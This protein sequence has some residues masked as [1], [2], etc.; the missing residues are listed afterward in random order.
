MTICLLQIFISVN[1]ALFN[2]MLARALVDKVEWFSVI[3]MSNGFITVVSDFS[4]DW[5]D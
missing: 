1:L 3:K 2:D 4:D 5:N